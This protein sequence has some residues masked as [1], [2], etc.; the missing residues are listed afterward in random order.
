MTEAWKIKNL[1]ADYFLVAFDISPVNQQLLGLLYSE[2]NTSKTCY[3]VTWFQFVLIIQFLSFFL[4]KTSYSD[5]IQLILPPAF[6]LFIADVIF[7]FVVFSSGEIWRI[8]A[9]GEGKD[10]LFL[11]GI[12]WR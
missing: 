4:K 10:R 11:N 7:S 8:L 6:V 2:E 5:Y 9:F 12:L 3:W 1:N